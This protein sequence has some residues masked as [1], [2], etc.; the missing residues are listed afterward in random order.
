[1][2]GLLAS[3]DADAL[4]APTEVAP[5]DLDAC[6]FTLRADG[7]SGDLAPVRCLQDNRR[8]YRGAQGRG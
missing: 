1:M 6:P 2:R 4:D 5:V 7:F 3:D 8:L